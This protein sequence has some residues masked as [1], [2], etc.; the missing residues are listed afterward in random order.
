[1]NF[2][3]VALQILE[4]LQIRPKTLGNYKSVFRLYIQP[5]LEGLDIQNVKREHIQKI[6]KPLPPQTGAVTLA[7]LK[8]IYREAIDYG[9]VENSPASNVRKP[10]THVKP[11]KFLSVQE[12]EEITFPKY[13]TQI[14]FLA[15]HGLRW[16][17]AV[18]LEEDDIRDGRVIINKSIHGPTKTKSGVRSVP[19]LS[20]FKR[21]PRTPR[22]LRK[23]LSTS[24]VHIHSL[25][26]TYAYLLKTSGIHVTTAQKLLGHSSPN[27]TLGIY[28]GFRDSE[29][30]D[31]GLTI[32]DSL[33]SR[34]LGIT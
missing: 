17:E 19:H 4:S 28:T 31:A 10:K 7:V 21:F 27:I 1:M 24:G 23:E 8:T 22:G 34:N 26:H 16:G 25:R 20:D 9:Y 32:I 33:K 30:D 29:I 13:G 14:M 15:M 6:I 5:A 18:A 3:Q 2:E 11:R 12:L